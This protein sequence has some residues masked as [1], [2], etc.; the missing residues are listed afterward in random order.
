MDKPIGH[1]ENSETGMV[2][3]GTP[4]NPETQVK[5]I[6]FCL[7]VS[8]SFAGVDINGAITGA[9]GIR[10]TEFSPKISSILLQTD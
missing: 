6:V 8:S 7:N 1:P 9:V 4:V 2:I 5:A 3:C 10:K